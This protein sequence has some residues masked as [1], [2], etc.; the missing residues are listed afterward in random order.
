[1]RNSTGTSKNV[2]VVAGKGTT[3]TAAGK[4][5]M[6]KK[7][8]TAENGN[9]MIKSFSKLPEKSTSSRPIKKEVKEDVGLQINTLKGPGVPKYPQF[10]TPFVKG[11]PKSNADHWLGKPAPKIGNVPVPK[12]DKPVIQKPLEVK[13]PVKQIQIKPAPSPKPQ[14]NPVQAK[15][16]PAPKP[17]KNPVP[18]PISR[19]ESG[20]AAKPKPQQPSLPVKPPVKKVEPEAPKPAPKKVEPEKPKPKTPAIVDRKGENEKSK[21][22]LS[23]N[24]K[25]TNDK[26]VAT[27]P[28]TKVTIDKKP[29]SE[30]SP[31]SLL[32]CFMAALSQ[33]ETIKDFSQ[34]HEVGE[35]IE[36]SADSEVA[37]K[38][39]M[40]CKKDISFKDS[41]GVAKSDK[42]TN[43]AILEFLYN[44]MASIRIPQFESFREQH[45]AVS[46][47][48]IRSEFESK[49]ASAKSS[50]SQ[51][52]SSMVLSKLLDSNKSPF[53][54]TSAFEQYL[55]H[56]S[57]EKPSDNADN[58]ELAEQV[59]EKYR[60]I[61]ASQF[62]ENNR[63]S[64]PKNFFEKTGFAVQQDIVPAAYS[65]FSV[66]PNL[67]VGFWEIKADILASMN[68]KPVVFC[69][70]DKKRYKIPLLKTLNG[71]DPGYKT[72]PQGL[73]KDYP[74]PKPVGAV[75]LISKLVPDSD[76]DYDWMHVCYNP[77]D[78]SMDWLLPEQKKKT[79]YYLQFDKSSLFAFKGANMNLETCIKI[80][81]LINRKSLSKLRLALET[82]EMG[83]FDP[84]ATVGSLVDYLR[85]YI[86]SD[87]TVEDFIFAKLDGQKEVK[88]SSSTQ[89]LKDVLSLVGWTEERANN[90]QQLSYAC[91]ITNSKLS[92]ELDDLINSNMNTV[93][94][95]EK[96]AITQGS[97]DTC[98]KSN[99]G[100]FFDFMISKSLDTDLEVLE[101][102]LGILKNGDS[103]ERWMPTCL[104][105][106]VSQV[107]LQIIDPK[108]P[109]TIGHFNGLF[110]E[111][112]LQ[113][114]NKYYIKAV[115]TKQGDSYKQYRVEGNTYYDNGK[116][117]K[118]ASI[119]DHLITH[120]I[121][122]REVHSIN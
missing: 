77:V 48:S 13:V 1:M 88:A 66:L 67:S 86:G 49:I 104:V 21:V 100:D 79:D 39:F 10:P 52:S 60:A 2:K 71:L 18:K 11:E 16:A 62:K 58:D 120:V 89:N 43:D 28:G 83:I 108:R 47:A 23:Q 45:Q 97:K 98:L 63:K 115:I 68:S 101:P 103:L 92:S 105:F 64:L 110:E 72:A 75:T 5:P 54:Q 114:S 41:I 42:N 29:A 26:P 82:M 9:P 3:T 80:P 70:P 116:A 37:K 36:G 33:I 20:P 87:V 57:L 32:A 76:K 19:K 91:I 25:P 113:L 119:A 38:F 96:T 53:F 106:D 90:K 74:Y 95:T 81:I 94:A 12:N 30:A 27:K 121:F 112:G 40:G 34:N 61:L 111:S 6:I 118:L 59:V 44:L 109:L 56:L 4:S 15:P 69:L 51:T 14:A 8:T 22:G 35:L 122:S 55:I 73:F 117:L 107:G 102:S 85:S 17:Q 7:E 65:K 46:L 84:K 93:T 24:E 78:S 99:L 50:L 31:S